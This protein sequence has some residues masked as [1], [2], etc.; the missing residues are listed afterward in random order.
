MNRY[1]RREAK[2]ACNPQKTSKI[3]LSR[4]AWDLWTFG[5]FGI[6]V[7]GRFYKQYMKCKSTHAVSMPKSK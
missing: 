3:P 6:L 4:I 7:D 2:Y 1:T 5:S